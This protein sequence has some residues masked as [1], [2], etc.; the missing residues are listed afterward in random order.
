MVFSIVFGIDRAAVQAALGNIK[1][2]LR[3]IAS[4]SFAEV[5]AGLGG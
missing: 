3:M 2:I 5:D 4:A 1:G